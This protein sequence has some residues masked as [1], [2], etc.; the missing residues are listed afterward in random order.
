M[1]N[2]TKTIKSVLYELMIDG[3]KYEKIGNKLYE[4]T[5]FDDDGFEIYLDSFTHTVTDPS[6]TIYENYIPLDSGVENQFAKD[7]ET[8][9]NIEF[10]FKLPNWFKIPTPIGNYNPDWAIVF[11]GEKKIYFVAE[12]K[13]EG[14]EL[15]KS[16]KLKIKCGKE[17]FKKFDGVVYKQVTT[18]KDLTI[19]R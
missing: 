11:K 12:T 19:H 7:C 6:K 10:Y 1:D 14:Q 16:E 3:I 4:M 5:L 2:A 17:H 8:S 13:S 15:L 9:E 18:V